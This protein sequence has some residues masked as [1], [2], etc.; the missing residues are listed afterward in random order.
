MSVTYKNLNMNFHIRVSDGIQYG[1][2]SEGQ[3]RFI[4]CVKDRR[5]VT[6]INSDYG[7]CH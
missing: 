2:K 4:K 5:Q 6:L 1:V 7:W 3:T